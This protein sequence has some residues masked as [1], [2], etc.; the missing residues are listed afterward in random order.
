MHQQTLA[1]RYAFA[2]ALL[3]YL[4]WVVDDNRYDD[5][6]D[7]DGGHGDQEDSIAPT[8]AE[9]GARPPRHLLAQLLGAP[10]LALDTLL[11]LL[12]HGI[13]RVVVRACTHLLHTAAHDA[14]IALG[15]LL[16]RIGRGRLP[17]L[18]RLCADYG[19]AAYDRSI[20]FSCW[21]TLTCTGASAGH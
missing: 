12:L 4:K 8:E 5:D 10:L 3:L 14:V 6:G 19:G 1:A 11:A 20:A 2:D 15:L 16:L 13:G 18:R 7:D 17:G 21:L 9:V